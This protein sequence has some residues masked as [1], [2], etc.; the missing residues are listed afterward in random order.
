MRCGVLN[1]VSVHTTGTV[2]KPTHHSGAIRTKTHWHPLNVLR[3]LK[4]LKLQRSLSTFN[5]AHAYISP[6][7]TV[8]CSQFSTEEVKKSKCIWRSGGIAPI[9]INLST[10]WRW[11]VS[12]Y[13]RGAF[14]S[15][16]RTRRLQFSYTG[17]SLVQP[18]AGWSKICLRIGISL[19]FFYLW[20]CK[21]NTVVL[22]IL[23]NALA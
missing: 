8:R 9:I 22:F 12:L 6:L 19:P 16:S 2:S 13:P 11:V 14:W 10:R 23:I 17:P 1:N 15:P 3:C 18:S 7:Q 5:Y 4:Y 21:L 20:P